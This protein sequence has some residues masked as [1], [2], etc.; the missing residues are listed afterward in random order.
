MITAVMAVTTILV[1]VATTVT[2]VNDGNYT[3]TM[4]TTVPMVTTVTALSAV[5]TM[6]V[7]THGDNT[8]R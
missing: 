2:A 6:T 1:M 8:L 4:V 3:V 7:V 5:T